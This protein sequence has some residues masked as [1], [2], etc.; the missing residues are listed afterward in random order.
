MASFSVICCAEVSQKSS[1]KG[2]TFCLNFWVGWLQ[3]ITVFFVL[4]GWVWS[5]VWGV[6]F[7][8]AAVKRNNTMVTTTTTNTMYP[9]NP[10]LV[11]ETLPG[12]PQP[13]YGA[14]NPSF[15]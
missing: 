5:I 7:V 11:N 3:M 15:A 10:R 1:G 8:Q 13:N 2:G 14:N 4:F 6:A 9:D 12:Y